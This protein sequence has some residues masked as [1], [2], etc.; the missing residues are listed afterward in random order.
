MHHLHYHQLHLLAYPNP[1]TRPERLNI[2]GEIAGKWHNQL[3]EDYE[4]KRQAVELYR[5]W[6]D[7][8]AQYGDTHVAADL[9]FRLAREIRLIR[10]S[11]R[12]A[13]RRSLSGSTSRHIQTHR[14]D[15]LD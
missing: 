5:D 2:T 1:K 6:Q 11:T 3:I 4:R 13:L 10:S 12:K 7:A 15:R 8:L 9:F 14:R